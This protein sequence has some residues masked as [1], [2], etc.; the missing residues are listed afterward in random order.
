MYTIEWKK[1]CIGIIALALLVFAAIYV[2]QDP[3]EIQPEPIIQGFRTDS[4]L[5]SEFESNTSAKEITANEYIVNIDIDPETYYFSGLSTIRYYN[6]TDKQLNDI[7]LNTYLNSFNKDPKEEGKN[8][9]PAKYGWMNIDSV[10]INNEKVTLIKEQLGVKVQLKQP[11][12]PKQSIEMIVSFEAKLPNGSERVGANNKAL[13]ASNFLP[14]LAVYEEKG[15]D[16]LKYYPIGTS[17][18]SDIANYTVTFSTPLE[19]TVIGTGSEVETEEGNKKL[20]KITAKMVRDF[21]FTMSKKYHKETQETENGVRVNLYTYSPI[22]NTK[23]ILS[24]AV[25]ALTYYNQ[26][27]GSYPYQEIDIMENGMI[28]EKAEASPGLI[29]ISAKS[30]ENQELVNFRLAYA[31]GHQWFYNVVGSDG[32]TDPWMDRALVFYLQLG[33]FYTPRGVEE[34]MKEE[35]KQL[36]K[37]L[38]NIRET[39]LSRS[40]DDYTSD[41]SYYWIVYSKGRAMFYA[42]HGKMGDEKFKKFLQEYYKTYAYRN[43]TRKEFISLAESIYGASLQK[44]FE[45]WLE[46]EGIPN[47][48][49]TPFEKQLYLP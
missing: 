35:L 25:D 43:V 6:N 9:H 14:T 13:W 27:I 12:P 46:G 31:I 21:A 30:L 23:Q 5:S 24:R 4:Y 49:K 41:T 36:D 39:R 45:E 34:V 11:L 38:N 2:M 18:Y 28:S 17:F 37:E 44:F 16:K 22:K 48:T 20:T 19:Y 42:L 1:I 32:K 10:V 8:L 40:I 3:I 33:Y 47:I 29:M 7:Y 15:W 26:R